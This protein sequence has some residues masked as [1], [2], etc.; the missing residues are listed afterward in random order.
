MARKQKSNPSMSIV[1]TVILILLAVIV[2]V[3]SGMRL[4]VAFL[5]GSAG[6]IWLIKKSF[7]ESST[8]PPRQKKTI[9][10]DSKGQ[11]TSLSNYEPK[12]AIGLNVSNAESLHSDFHAVRVSSPE[13]K[14]TIPKPRDLSPKAR[15]IGKDETIAVG[16]QVLKGGMV[17]FAEKADRSFNQEPSLIDGQLPV[18]A[19]HVDLTEKLTGYWPS[20]SG[21]SPAARRGYLQWLSE[22]RSARNVDVGYVFIFFYGLERRAILDSVTDEAARS[23]LPTIVTKIERLKTLYGDN[24]SFR[25]YASN[26]LN[27]I[28]LVDVEPQMYL[29]APPR[30]E[31]S[32][33]EMPMALR[34]A[35]G[36]MALDKHPLNAVWALPWVKSDPNISRRTPV[37]RCVDQ[38]DQLFVA[39]YSTR[40]PNGLVLNQ[41]KTMLK[42][43]YRSASS[44]LSVPAMALGDIPDVSVTSATRNKLQALVDE[45]TIVLDPYSRYLGRNPGG[46]SNL[47]GILQLPVALWPASAKDVIADL[48]LQVGDEHLVMTL[49]DLAGLFGSL[50]V[51]PRGTIVAL[52]RAFESLNIGFEPDV[53]SGS[54]APK[55]WTRSYCSQR[56]TVT[57]A[58]GQPRTITLQW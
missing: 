17:Y 8:G 22:G 56:L 46:A 40:Y 2:A 1:A 45:C 38:F 9:L 18:Q 52:A 57:E 26:L 16:G 10:A 7:T 28:Q 11:T 5:T 32:G 27:H 51:L 58:C 19:M 43:T 31:S 14:F 3:P 36:Q 48:Q 39:Q 24:P 41:N 34:L 25:N 20:Y 33:F 21:I 23:E 30:F 4:T 35:L 54:R 29:K 49:G 53:L 15:W 44:R 13:Q 50:G 47:E 42:I 12:S 55:F 37:S 6:L